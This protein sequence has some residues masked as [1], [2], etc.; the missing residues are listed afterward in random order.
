MLR[1]G[2]VGDKVSIVGSLPGFD[3]GRIEGVEMPASDWWIYS[4]KMDK[5]GVELCLPC[6]EVMKG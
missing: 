3:T 2:K 4:I 5:T 6:P 1:D